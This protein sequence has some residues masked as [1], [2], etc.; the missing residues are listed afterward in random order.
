MSATKTKIVDLFKNYIDDYINTR[1][2]ALI[3]TVVGTSFNTL[4]D[5][6]STYLLNNM[7]QTV[8]LDNT[9]RNATII[10]DLN[11]DAY[12]THTYVTPGTDREHELRPLKSNVLYILFSH[13]LKTFIVIS[14][15]MRDLFN[16]D[17]Y[18]SLARTRPSASA[19]RYYTLYVIGP[20][21]DTV[22]EAINHAV[23]GTSVDGSE[24]ST[25]ETV[26]MYHA[27]WDPVNK[28]LDF[29]FVGEN[30][31]KSFDNVFTNEQNK[32]K[33]FNHVSKWVHATDIFKSL[34]VTY[35]LGILLYGPPGT[36]KTSMAKAVAAHFG[37][38]LNIVDMA[39]FCPDMSSAIAKHK[40]SEINIYLL[41]DIDYIFGKREQD[42]TPEE[43]AAGQAILQLLDGANSASNV[44]FIATTNCLESLDP[45][46]VRD[47]RFDLKIPMDNL[48]KVEALKMIESMKL[49]EEDNFDDLI[50]TLEFPVNP[51]R[52]QNLVVQH[53]F[54]HISD[55]DN[56]VK[57]EHLD[58]SKPKK[59]RERRADLWDFI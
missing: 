45:A 5:M 52:L 4:T 30:H 38:D 18:D 33:L 8:L 19:F 22:V 13:K 51:A 43:K 37:Y 14:T 6:F 9:R 36:G 23:Y 15:Y 39:S 40:H 44:I 41:E 24:Y 35:K 42:R 17:L 54:E 10:N 28:E 12:A 53:I 58:S 26:C 27:G 50:S 55:S 20:N 59:K 29:T 3:N 48:S 46:L 25:T 21:C 34:G 16:C 56:F 47:G 57:Q 7:V 49:N 11:P 32:A 2:T 1:K 31:T